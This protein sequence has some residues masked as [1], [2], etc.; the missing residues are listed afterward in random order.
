MNFQNLIISMLLA[1][2][3]GFALIGFIYQTSI[4]N[5]NYEIMKDSRLNK[6]FNS[7]NKTLNNYQN[8]AQSQINAS[9]NEPLQLGSDNIILTFITGTYKL[10]TSVIT[11]I[12]N[13][14]T[15]FINDTLHINPIILGILSTIIILSIVLVIYKLVSI[16]E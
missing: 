3:F 10:F 9:S 16:V 11:Q 6:T 7:L 14:L 15:I 4:D 13:T 8:T 2:L 5:D 12:F 1:G